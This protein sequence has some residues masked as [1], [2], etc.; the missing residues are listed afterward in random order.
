MD[1]VFQLRREI[2]LVKQW[3]DSIYA[4]YTRLRLWEEFDVVTCLPCCIC[5][6]FKK[7]IE[8]ANNITPFQFLN[9]TPRFD[10]ILLWAKFICLMVIILMWSCRWI[11]VGK[12]KI[13]WCFVIL[14][15]NTIWFQLR[16][17]QE[18]CIVLLCFIHSCG[19]VGFLQLSGV[20]D[21]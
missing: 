12:I 11:F 9:G 4:Y 10:Q 18:I 20:R 3:V 21:W 5:D 17:I 7:Y 1:R 15:L 13:I 19:Y 2:F 16:N 6:I 8:H 14:T